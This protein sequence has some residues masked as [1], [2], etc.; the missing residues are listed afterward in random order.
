MRQIAT[1]DAVGHILCH[2]IT[3]IVKDVKKD[4]AF[5]RG[6]VIKQEDIEV[7]HSL[8]KFNLFVWE[9]QEGMMHEEDAAQILKKIS[10]NNN[11]RVSDVK[12]GKVELFS[13]IDGLFQVDVGRVDAIN[14]LGEIS[15]SSRHNNVQVKKGDKV[16]ASRV[17]PLLIGEDKM[18]K[19]REIGGDAPLF[20]ILPYKPLKAAIVTTGREISKGR[21]KD[22]F[23]PVIF[24]KLEEYGIYVIAQELAG[25][26]K[27]DIKD[28]ILRFCDKGAEIIIC[29]GGMSIDPDDATPGA[30][31]ATGAEAITYGTPVSPGNMLMLAYL[32]DI[33]VVG[34]PGC[35][36]YEKATIFD[37]VLP[38][39]AAGV[40]MKN[41][42]FAKMGVGGLC[43][44]CKPCFYPAC[45]FGKGC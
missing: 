5:R 29:T 45:A 22:A 6:H 11:M 14:S 4:A 35:V 28:A 18:D 30:I 3:E 43:L 2:D 36:M 25:D 10:Q 44:G 23:T 16:A 42:D 37:I 21:I 1:K 7:L 20:K 15:M 12:E 13:E 24:K 27:E 34:L 19:V 40:K 38:R 39:L 33:P 41:E 32:G 8:G 9:K 26:E 31:R 17:I